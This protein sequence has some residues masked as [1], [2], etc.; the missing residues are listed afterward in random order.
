MLDR[1]ACA[2][3]GAAFGLPYGGLLALL[4]LAVTHGRS[5]IAYVVLVTVA[6]FAILGFV[7]GPFIGDVVAAVLH[8]IVGLFTG[9]TGT[10][11][12]AENLEPEGSG[13]MN[14]LFWFGVGTAVVVLFVA[15]Y[16]K[17]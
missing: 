13:L 4:A 16:G 12:V 9:L 10:E 17:A 7:I 1:F 15:L 6:V 5:G 2:S 14:S 8:F 11:G 3:I